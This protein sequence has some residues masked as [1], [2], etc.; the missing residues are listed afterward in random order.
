MNEINRVQ[1]IADSNGEIVRLP[2]DTTANP[3]NAVYKP[4][5][6]R[7]VKCPG[8]WFMVSPESL[9]TAFVV[10]LKNNREVS[11]P[12]LLSPGMVYP[13]DADTIQI[14]GVRRAGE[15]WVLFGR[16]SVVPSYTRAETRAAYRGFEFRVL[17][18]TNIKLKPTDA[19][20][21][22]IWCHPNSAPNSANPMV[23]GAA[24]W[25][26]AAT[27]LY[28]F[29]YTAAHWTLLKF[30]VFNVDVE[31]ESVVNVRCLSSTTPTA[32]SFTVAAVDINPWDRLGVIAIPSAANPDPT[33]APA[34]MIGAL[35]DCFGSYSRKA[36]FGYSA[37]GSSTNLV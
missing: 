5:Y 16:G 7:P 17:P 35:V 24:L 14:V 34:T 23:C 21:S 15:I 27:P 12:V 32:T 11:G 3:N 31:T 25:P 19:G 4:F 29:N 2:G 6:D 36:E 33:V 1:I 8:D 13:I 9:G 30:C 18:V 28:F 22:N 10:F 37:V 26:G 20:F